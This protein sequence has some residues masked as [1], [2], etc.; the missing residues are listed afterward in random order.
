M[1]GGGV[2][3][4]WEWRPLLRV[5]ALHAF[6]YCERL[7]SLDQALERPVAEGRVRCHADNITVRAPLDE[8]AR[9]GVRV[10]VS[11]PRTNSP[12]SNAR[13]VIPPQMPKGVEH[14]RCASPSCAADPA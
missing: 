4:A 8:P 14:T 1:G 3:N 6:A 7:F 5:M 2:L 13:R 12:T 9:R 11:A 10:A